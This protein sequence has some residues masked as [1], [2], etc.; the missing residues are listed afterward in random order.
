MKNSRARKPPLLESVRQ[1]GKTYILRE[2]GEREYED[3][4]YFTFLDDPV[5]YNIF[6]TGL[7]PKG[8]PKFYHWVEY[9]YIH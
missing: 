9:N 7:K 6:Q 2:F 8:C 5:I 1:C 4:A 3:V